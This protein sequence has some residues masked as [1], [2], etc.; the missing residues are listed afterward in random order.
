MIL[1]KTAKKILK[2]LRAREKEFAKMPKQKRDVDSSK[3]TYK[4]IKSMFPN[5][6][7]IVVSM[8]I[9]YLLEENFIYNH[10]DG[11]ENTFEIQEAEK[12]NSKF[13][14]GEKGIAYLEQIK[15]ILLAKIIPICIAFLSLIISCITF[16]FK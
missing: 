11:K 13:V 15:Y 2:K 5:T 10:I 3:V 9:K 16:F 12:G 4:E 6:S 1:S 7:H 14:I 8:T